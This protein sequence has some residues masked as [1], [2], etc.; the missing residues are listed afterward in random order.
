MTLGLY[1]VRFVCRSVCM[2]LGL[3]ALLGALGM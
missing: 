2:P 3:Y 1:D